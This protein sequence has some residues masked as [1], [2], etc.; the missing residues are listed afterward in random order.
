MSHVQDTGQ[1]LSNVSDAV[2]AAMSDMLSVATLDGK[3][4]STGAATSALQARVRCADIFYAA[5]A[6]KCTEVPGKVNRAHRSETNKH[7][8]RT[9]T[10]STLDI[11]F[12]LLDHVGHHTGR[13]PPL[14]SPTLGLFGSPWF[15]C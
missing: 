2:T 14:H 6:R 3:F 11:P 12:S 5:H 9:Q 7:N 10:S 15:G 8:F 1:D 13:R 4:L